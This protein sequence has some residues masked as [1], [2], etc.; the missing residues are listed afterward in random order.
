M[1]CNYNIDSIS[2]NWFASSRLNSHKVNPNERKL[3]IDVAKHF[4][5]CTF[6]MYLICIEITPNNTR[7][8]FNFE[9]KWSKKS[10]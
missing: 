2:K 8:K 6:H 4:I 7:R 9:I 10:N 1:Q 5:N 3:N